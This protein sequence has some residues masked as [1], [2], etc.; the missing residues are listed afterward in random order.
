[1]K[2]LVTGAKS[3]LGAELIHLKT[4][5]EIISFTRAELDICDLKVVA[6][7]L[8]TQ[9]PNW[10]VNTAAYTAVDRAELE[11]KAAFAVNCTGVENLAKVCKELAIPLLHISTDYVFSGN[12]NQPYKE[13]DRC[14]PINV[15]GQSKLAGELALADILPEHII[16]RTSWLY[17]CYGKNFMKIILK[18]AK[19]KK[20]L[21]IVADQQGT[22]TTTYDLA[23]AIL[24]IVQADTQY[25]GTY[26]CSNQGITTWF[27]FAKAIFQQQKSNFST[28]QL[29]PITSAEYIAEACRPIY[30]VLNCDKL[31]NKYGITLPMWQQALKS[32]AKY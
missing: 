20:E 30:S 27:E 14:E 7:I 32:I 24:K 3:Q 16:L 29:T 2:I 1:M 6:K 18:L 22:P 23:T 4:P 17:G 9:Q 26:H 21:S 11:P 31:K 12:K 8:K 15:Y 13:D 28:P 5:L 10:V 25:W 19:E